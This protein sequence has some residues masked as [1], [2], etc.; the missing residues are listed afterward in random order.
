VTGEACS[1]NWRYDEFINIYSDNLNGRD[2]LGDMRRR[3]DII[4]TD[5][6]EEIYKSV[7]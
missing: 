6:K 5:L 3:E 2:N 7:D 1:T 4:K